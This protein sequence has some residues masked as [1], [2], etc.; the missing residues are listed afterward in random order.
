MKW[1]TEGGREEGVAWG[2]VAAAAAAAV[3][4]ETLAPPLPAGSDPVAPGP[5]FGR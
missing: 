3:G 4:S 1:S 2:G 5:T